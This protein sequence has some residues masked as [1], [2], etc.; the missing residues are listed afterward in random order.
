VIR[1]R[2]DWPL[3]YPNM[4]PGMFA[5]RLC[6][7]L[8]L[9]EGNIENIK[10]QIITQVKLELIRKGLTLRLLIILREIQI[11]F[12]EQR[13]RLK[14]SNLKSKLHHLT[15]LEGIKERMKNKEEQSKQRDKDK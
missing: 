2:F 7:V 3:D 5:E 1:E 15:F 14:I 6:T 11:R 4:S 8:S 9:P 12:R 10:K 13:Q